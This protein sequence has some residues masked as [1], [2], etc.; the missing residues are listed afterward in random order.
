M[1]LYSQEDVKGWREQGNVVVCID[2]VWNPHYAC[3]L[4][5]AHGP[6]RHQGQP[7]DRDD[8]RFL[9]G[10]QYALINRVFYDTRRAWT[11]EAEKVFISFGGADPLD[12]TAFILEQPCLRSYECHVVLGTDYRG[13]ADDIAAFNPKMHIYENLTQPE[14]AEVMAQCDVAMGSGGGLSLELCAI[15][16]PTVLIAVADDQVEPCK[17]FHDQG[18]AWYAGNIAS[19][20]PDAFQKTFEAFV[21]GTDSRRDLYY[22]TQKIFRHSGVTH[23]A[24]VLRDIVQPKKRGVQPFVYA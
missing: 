9:V 22:E 3:D 16:L 20:T 12:F 21:S 11:S 6:H 7:S 4:V 1:A 10:P 18:L 2:D 8:C 13:K 5:I 23:I 17:A 14:L 15:G 24:K 19:L